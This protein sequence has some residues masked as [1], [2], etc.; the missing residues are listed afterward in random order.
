VLADVDVSGMKETLS[1]LAPVVRLWLNGATFR[2]GV[3]SMN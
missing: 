3:T 1:L 2:E